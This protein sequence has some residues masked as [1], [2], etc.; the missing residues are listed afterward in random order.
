M[1]ET[2]FILLDFDGFQEHERCSALNHIPT[3]FHL[4]NEQVDLL[5]D[6]GGELLRTN[7]EYQ[8]LLNDQGEG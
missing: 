1:L 5:I 4:S 8:L 7:P 6:A 3:S 2:Y